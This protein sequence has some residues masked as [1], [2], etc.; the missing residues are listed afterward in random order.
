MCISVISV[1]QSKDR[2]AVVV[3]ESP[4]AQDIR[5]V[6]TAFPAMQEH[7]RSFCLLIG[8]LRIKSLQSDIPNRVKEYFLG[9]LQHQISAPLANAATSQQGLG[10]GAS[11]IERGIENFVHVYL[12]ALMPIFSI[13]K[14]L[15]NYEHVVCPFPRLYNENRLLLISVMAIKFNRQK[16][17]TFQRSIPSFLYEDERS[18][19][20]KLIYSLFMLVTLGLLLKND[21]SKQ[22]L[23]T[24]SE[25]CE[26]QYRL[27]TIGKR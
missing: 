7:D 22:P 1:V 21:P 16:T 13:Y 26:V 17:G 8:L 6:D 3:Q 24:T 9:S 25:I 27:N 20:M 4:R 5:R 15:E 12:G 18:T 19:T 2:V 23:F 14:D 11:E 10:K